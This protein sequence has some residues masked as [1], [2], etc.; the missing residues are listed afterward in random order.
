MARNQG[1]VVER[2]MSASRR[3][4]NLFPGSPG[5]LPWIPSRISENSPFASKLTACVSLR[6]LA[7]AAGT[8]WLPASAFLSKILSGM[9]SGNTPK[10]SSAI[11][12]SAGSSSRFWPKPCATT[13]STR[14]V[15]RRIGG[16]RPG[17]RLCARTRRKMGR[18]LSMSCPLPRLVSI[19]CSMKRA[20]GTA[21]SRSLPT[22]R[23]L[24][25]WCG[26]FSTSVLRRRG[27][28]QR[29]SASPLPSCRTAR[30]GCAAG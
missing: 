24:P 1:C 21:C 19:L 14:C 18:R 30:S 4:G 29:L 7:C 12:P 27:R 11:K 28:L 20:I 5:G 22:S 3:T 10:G 26:W 2:Y 23:S 9:C 17:L 25:M 8:Q 6:S 13:S 16:R 15:R